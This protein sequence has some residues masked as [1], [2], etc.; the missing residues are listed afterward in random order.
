MKLSPLQWPKKSEKII[1]KNFL[2][3][4]FPV[5]GKKNT[6]FIDRPGAICC[7]EHLF[8]KKKTPPPPLAWGRRK[9][10]LDFLWGQKRTEDHHCLWKPHHYVQN[11]WGTEST[12]A[13]EIM[14]VRILNY[15]RSDFNFEGIGFQKIGSV[16]LL[17]RN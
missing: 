14:R 13:N 10:S 11:Y 17:V 3:F 12:T 16:Y 4:F 8:L 2:V 15:A 5:G 7:F 9:K 6:A 1:S